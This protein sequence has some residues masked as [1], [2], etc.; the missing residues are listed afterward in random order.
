MNG[1]LSPQ[2]LETIEH[3]EDAWCILVQPAGGHGVT[4]LHAMR[5]SQ[6]EAI[7]VAKEQMH[8]AESVAVVRCTLVLKHKPPEQTETA[9]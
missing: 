6:A 8:T 2:E 5:V 3:F 4:F 7:A 1:E 9:E